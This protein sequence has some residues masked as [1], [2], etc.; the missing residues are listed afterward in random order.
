MK[1]FADRT[2]LLRLW[3]CLILMVLI[4]PAAALNQPSYA[5][6]FEATE[7]SESPQSEQLNKSQST[8]LQ[9]SQLDS[10]SATPADQIGGAQSQT[11]PEDKPIV[12]ARK[13]LLSA[14]NLMVEGKYPEAVNCYQQLLDESPNN[15]AAL[16]GLGMALGRQMKLDEAD[17]QFNKVLELDPN[18]A[19]A[20]CGKA[21]V[22]LSR[23]QT[24]PESDKKAR[25]NCL[26]QAGRECNKALDADAR[27][28][29]AHYLLGKV[30]SAEGRLDRA[31]QAFAGAVKLDPHYSNAWAAL[32]EVQAQEGKF[33]LAAETLQHAISINPNN[34]LAYFA[35]GQMYMQQGQI[36]RAVREYNMSIYKNSIH[37]QV[38]LALAKAYALQNDNVA[39][40]K[41]YQE[42]LKVK[43][44]DAQAYVGLASVYEA[45][46]EI[47]SAAAKLRQGLQSLPKDVELHLALADANLRLGKISQA[48]LDYQVALQ[49]SPAS[50][51]AATGLTRAL[52]VRSLKESTGGFL[53]ASDYD[54][55]KVLINQAL[56]ADGNDLALKYAAAAL[57][58]LSGQ[59]TNLEQIGAPKTDGERI[60]LAQVLLIQNKFP[61]A[62]EQLR[63]VL[64]NV[65]EAKEAFSLADL[66]FALRDLDIADSAC[67][68]ALTFAN[69]DTRARQGIEVI[70]KTRQLAKD[71][72]TQ[73]EDL[74]RRKMFGQAAEKFHSAVFGDPRNAEA[75]RGLAESLERLTF[76][77]AAETAR[78]YRDAALQY[79]VYVQLTPAMPPK[80]QEKFTKKVGRLDA[81]AKK[82]DTGPTKTPA[83]QVSA[84]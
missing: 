24:M 10:Q 60:A 21:M 26:K 54:K 80:V 82:L 32:G 13:Q 58:A 18:H 36:D 17:T 16:A 1:T 64:N 30:Y 6:S 3:L 73:A 75:R 53:H 12:N 46:G 47:E 70:G 44:D 69:A 25:A 37:E 48:I 15:L 22:L 76:G 68:K 23:L 74:L 14:A 83:D 66:A 19:V 40:I 35:L 33:A 49:L 8:D 51:D 56:A 57:I 2:V 62:D 38:H 77:S 84:R 79:K 52:Y 29:E 7:A 55:T 41:E 20:H 28:V 65:S 4:G 27:V 61:E 67:H 39:A 31:E 43:P 11:K 63:R 9:P 50:V 72:Y 71:N 45:K 34:S 78:N 5:R 59:S 81:E 42:A